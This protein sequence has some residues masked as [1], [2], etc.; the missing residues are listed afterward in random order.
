MAIS[1]WISDFCSSNLVDADHA[2]IETD[3]EQAR[4]S[5][6]SRRDAAAYAAPNEPV[7]AA[8]RDRLCAG[9]DVHL[10]GRQGRVHRSAGRR[11]NDRFLGTL[12][13]PGPDFRQHDRILPELAGTRHEH[14]PY[15]AGLCGAAPPH[16]DPTSVVYGQ[17]VSVPV[18]PRRRPPPPPPTP[19]PHPPPPP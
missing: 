4:S 19:P 1:D 2:P 15:R 3:D 7:A 6:R 11:R 16:L 9:C 8:A 5:I 10:G 14:Q 13:T 12:D 17:S 18:A